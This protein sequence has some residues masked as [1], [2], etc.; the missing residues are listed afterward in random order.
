MPLSA[1]FETMKET[2]KPVTAIVL[3]NDLYR[4]AS[5]EEVDEFFN[6]VKRLVV[7]DCVDHGI[8]EAIAS[9]PPKTPKSSKIKRPPSTTTQLYLPA[10]TFAESTGTLVSAEGRMQ[11]FFSALPP[12][13]IVKSGWQWCAEIFSVLNPDELPKWQNIE[14]IMLQCAEE[15]PFLNAITRAAPLSDYRIQGFKVARSP[16]RYSGRTAMHADV[17]VHEP[18]PPQDQDSPLA[19][20]ME[21]YPLQPPAALTPFYWAAGW[22]SIQSCNKYQREVGDSLRD[23]DPGVKLFTPDNSQ[24]N[25]FS[26]IPPPFRRKGNNQWLLLPLH[27]IFGSEELS[28]NAP[29]I[30]QRAPQP[31]IAINPQDAHAAGIGD[32]DE[33]EVKIHEKVRRLSCRIESALPS[34]VAGLPTGLKALNGIQ[35]P[36]WVTILSPAEKHAGTEK[37]FG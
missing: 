14:H 11:R 7:V 31:F 13:E 34:S 20:S 33:V 4:R 23:G 26:Q 36:T 37:R 12:S 27:F 1:A 16:H 29:G 22:N 32:G 9:I 17:N 25:Y 19:Y 2:H 30:A 8:A 6:K 10:A 15:E 35:L 5:E 3:E 18:R 21:G 24:V 28:A